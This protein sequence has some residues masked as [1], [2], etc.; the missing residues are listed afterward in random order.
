VMRP[1]SPGSTSGGVAGRRRRSSATSS[2]SNGAP[3][4]RRTSSRAVTTIR[5]PPRKRTEPSGSSPTS[6]IAATA[7][8]SSLEVLPAAEQATLM[9]ALK[10]GIQ[11]AFQLE[12]GELAAEPLP[13]EDDR[14]T[15]LLYE[16]SEG[17]AGVLRRLVS[18]PRALAAA[19]E[20]ALEICHFAPDGRTSPCHPVV[21]S[22]VKPPATTA[23]CPTPT[24]A[25]TSC[26]TGTWSS[27]C[28]CCW[29]GRIE[30]SGGT[31]SRSA[32]LETCAGSA[33]RAGAELA[34]S[35]RAARPGAAIHGAEGR[36]TPA[37]P[38]PTSS[39]RRSTT[40]SSSM[41][42]TTTDDQP[43]CRRGGRDLPGGPG[44][45]R[46]AVPLRRT[47]PLAEQLREYPSIYG[48]VR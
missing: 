5:C 28:S 48:E 29:P 39:T 30:T 33:T 26:S 6:T 44:L 37:R 38:G 2:T 19:A 42:R 43:S 15:I 34:R 36:S 9:A 24:S 16:A 47:R 21:G 31:D 20:A 10:N 27:T 22:P 7:W 41:G 23:C 45:H 17:G 18:E 3:G 25:T 14:R 13:T 11:I 32:H 40:P 35:A 8:S 46:P 12:D 1:R 4:S